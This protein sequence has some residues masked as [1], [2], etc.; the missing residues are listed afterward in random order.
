M[1]IFQ[2]MVRG[3]QK[4]ITDSL[5]SAKNVQETNIFIRRMYSVIKGWITALF[6][7]CHLHACHI[8]KNNSEFREIYIFF[9]TSITV[10]FHSKISIFQF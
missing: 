3:K 8:F 1:W 2:K 7:T 10:F 6:K 4:I 5:F 9:F